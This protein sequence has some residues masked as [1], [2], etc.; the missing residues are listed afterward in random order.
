MSAILFV[1]LLQSIPGKSR[2][3]V[4]KFP[5]PP[6]LQKKWEGS[7]NGINLPRNYLHDRKGMKITETSF[8]NCFIFL[9][10]VISEFRNPRKTNLNK[11]SLLKAP[12]GNVGF[13]P[14]FY[15]TAVFR[16]ATMR[17]MNWRGRHFSPLPPDGEFSRKI[18]HKTK[19]S[20]Q[21]LL[22]VGRGSF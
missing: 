6:H 17:N 15:L 5:A 3:Q 12:T 7:A 14:C 18:N 20:A 1:C 11:F 8:R 10:K 4:G 21:L 22:P 13:V 19:I 2:E 9:K 16:T